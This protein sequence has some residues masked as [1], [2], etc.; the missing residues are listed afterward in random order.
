MRIFF[1]LYP[2]YLRVWILQLW[3]HCTSLCSFSLHCLSGT[4]LQNDRWVTKKEDYSGPEK[5]QYVLW[6]NEMQLVTAVQCRHCIKLSKQLPTRKIVG[7]TKHLWRVAVCAFNKGKM[8]DHECWHRL[9]DAT[10]YNFVSKHYRC[11][12]TSTRNHHF[13]HSNHWFVQN[14]TVPCCM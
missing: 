1:P 14:G 8:E 9:S 12:D 3:V 11:V 7:G 2:L 6:Y 13:I 10:K 4:M 5:A